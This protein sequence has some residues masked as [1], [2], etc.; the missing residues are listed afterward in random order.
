MD[1]RSWVDQLFTY[2][3][4]AVLALFVLWVAPAQMKAFRQV[5]SENR[6]QQAVSGFIT[7]GCWLI[8]FAMVYYIYRFWPPRTVYLGSLG[9]H[10]SQVLLLTETPEL[11]ISSRPL[12]GNRLK[13]DYVIVTDSRQTD[14]GGAGDNFAFAYQWGPAAD[15]A[16]DFSLPRSL[17]QKHRIDVYPDPDHPHVL[18]YDDDGD[19][20]RP[21]KSLPIAGTQ[22]AA[23]PTTQAALVAAAYAQPHPIIDNSVI[24]EWLA[25]PNANLRAQAR[26]QLRQISPD[27]LRQL[28]QAPALSATAHDQINAELANRR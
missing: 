19:P 28:L 23:L 17:L 24:L 10:P 27:Q 26:A 12:P 2:G 4:Y 1:P 13:W 20:A 9:T 7:I 6:I 14:A 15:E 18:V 16:M 8:V 21:R 5:P 22:I 25:S 11:F 3:P